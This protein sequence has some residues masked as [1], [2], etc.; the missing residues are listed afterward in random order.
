MSDSRAVMLF[1]AEPQLI[2]YTSSAVKFDSPDALKYR[3]YLMLAEL[4]GFLSQHELQRD[5]GEQYEYSNVGM[6]LLGHLL[7]DADFGHDDPA[8][9]FVRAP[10][11]R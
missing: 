1:R 6:G 2:F 9:P 5:V 11:A 7:V 4:Y 3:I 10:R 8:A